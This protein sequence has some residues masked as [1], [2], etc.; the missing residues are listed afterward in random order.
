MVMVYCIEKIRN[1]ACKRGRC[2]GQSAG[3]L[4]QALH[5]MVS[6]GPHLILLVIIHHNLH[7]IQPAKETHSRELPWLGFF[8]VGQTTKSGL[9][10]QLILIS[11]TAAFASIPIQLDSGPTN[12][13]K[14]AFSMNSM[15]SMN[16][17]AWPKAPVLHKQENPGA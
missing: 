3:R 8:T 4:G 14:Q 10:K 15:V 9:P 12:K 16:Y 7:R 2:I 5:Q 11:W 6:H 1:K 13:Q 17:V